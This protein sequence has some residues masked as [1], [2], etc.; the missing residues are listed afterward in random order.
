[1]V[2]LVVAV[3]VVVVTRMLMTIL[4]GDGRNVLFEIQ[5]EVEIVHCRIGVP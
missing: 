2:M 4:F 5:I 3:V 1:M